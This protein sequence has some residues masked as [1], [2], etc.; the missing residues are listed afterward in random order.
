MVK[1][2]S[3]WDFPSSLGGLSLW[4]GIWARYTRDALQHLPWLVMLLMVLQKGT[5]SMWLASP[6]LPFTSWVTVD[7]APTPLWTSV[8][9]SLEK[10]I[11]PQTSCC[12][13]WEERGISMSY[14]RK[15]SHI[16]SFGIVWINYQELVFPLIFFFS[17]NLKNSR[18][19]WTKAN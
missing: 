16:T 12:Y 3:G 10:G 15:F 13:F 11:V 14:K 6:I 2:I 17:T 4:S 5:H 1:L 8:T 7:G 19:E 9:A 18:V